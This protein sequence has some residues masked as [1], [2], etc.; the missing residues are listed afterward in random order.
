M[1]FTGRSMEIV[2]RERLDEVI[3]N[4]KSFTLLSKEEYFALIDEIKTAQNITVTKTMRQYNLMK[5]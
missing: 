1:A 4:S 5:K 3:H 2:F